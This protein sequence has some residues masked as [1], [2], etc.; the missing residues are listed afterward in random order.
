MAVAPV[1]RRREGRQVK[2]KS[3]GQL[4]HQGAHRVQ[5]AKNVRIALVRT[6]LIHTESLS[7]VQ[8]RTFYCSQDVR[9]P[10]VVSKFPWAADCPE[11]VSWA[12]LTRP[13]SQL[14]N[15]G[16]SVMNVCS[17]SKYSWGHDL[18]NVPPVEHT[19]SS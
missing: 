17:V 8:A 19:I 15:S 13:E 2:D 6:N 14:H 7:G 3:G 16:Y 11:Q 5:Q 4:G 10:K 12:L 9:K 1:V 18:H